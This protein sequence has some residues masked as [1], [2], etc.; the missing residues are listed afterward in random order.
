MDEQRY[1]YAQHENAHYK[2]YSRHGDRLRS[3]DV[4]FDERSVW[5]PVQN[6]LIE[7]TNDLIFQTVYMILPVFLPKLAPAI[8]K[9]PR[10]GEDEANAANNE[11]EVLLIGQFLGI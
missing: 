11:S 9:E 8:N 1:P 4:P 3:D 10:P 2:V 6:R 7:R 5:R